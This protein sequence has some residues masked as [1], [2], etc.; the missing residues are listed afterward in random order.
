M[1][2]HPP[3]TNE[4]DYATIHDELLGSFSRGQVIDVFENLRF[5][6]QPHRNTRAPLCTVELD[7]DV[8]DAIVLAL[9]A[10]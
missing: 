10:R 7:R 9:R 1:G 4:T 6:R 8:R 2:A 3:R 5:K